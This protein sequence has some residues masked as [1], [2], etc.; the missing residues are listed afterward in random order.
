MTHSG[1]P[2]TLKFALGRNVAVN[3]LIG[4]SI[5]EAANLSLDADNDVITFSK[6]AT[7]PFQVNYKPAARSLPDLQNVENCNMAIKSPL[8]HIKKEDIAA[9]IQ[10]LVTKPIQ[11]SNPV[12]LKRAASTVTFEDKSDISPTSSNNLRMYF[13]C[14]I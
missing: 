10:V 9:Y 12:T 14:L 1:Q 4:M 5:I 11:K 6:I 3:T 2:V 13:S 7:K 8:P